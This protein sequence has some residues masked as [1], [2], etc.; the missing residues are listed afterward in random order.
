MGVIG[1]GGAGKPLPD[2]LFPGLTHLGQT[3]GQEKG[4]VRHVR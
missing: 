3:P 4:R 1:S 2:S